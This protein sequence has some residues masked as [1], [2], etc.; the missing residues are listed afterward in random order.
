MPRDREQNRLYMKQYFLDNP[1][2]NAWIKFRKRMREQYNLDI[3]KEVYFEYRAWAEENE[4]I[5]PLGRIKATKGLFDEFV[6]EKKLK[7]PSL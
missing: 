5:D 7:I 3:S 6:R 2:V 4:I 1:G